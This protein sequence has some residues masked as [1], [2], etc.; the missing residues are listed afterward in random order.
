VARQLYEWDGR[1]AGLIFGAF[2]GYQCFPESPNRV[3]RPDASY[4]GPSKVPG[5]I[6]PEGWMRVP[7][8]LAVEVLSPLDRSTQVSQRVRDYLEVGVQLVWI[9]DST[10]LEVRIYRPDGPREILYGDQELRDEAVLSGFT[11]PVK[12]LFAET[13]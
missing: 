6:M 12:E 4:I 8:D 13:R 1:G 7:P 10:L 9:V 3:I 2:A 5:G 11:C